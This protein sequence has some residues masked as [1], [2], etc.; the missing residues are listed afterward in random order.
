MNANNVFLCQNYMYIISNNC[1]DVL[2]VVEEF[3]AVALE[4]GEANVFHWHNVRIECLGYWLG[5][6]FLRVQT[7]AAACEEIKQ[8]HIADG[9]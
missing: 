1:M 2:A 5:F 7:N 3:I 9:I 4:R 8:N 6:I